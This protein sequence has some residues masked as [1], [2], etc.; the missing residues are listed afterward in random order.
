MRQIAEGKHA[1]GNAA[2]GLM[3][4]V[5]RKASAEIKSRSRR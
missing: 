4:A 3:L 1:S 5:E 2:T